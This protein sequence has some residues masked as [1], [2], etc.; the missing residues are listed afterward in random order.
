VER[1]CHHAG[2][3]GQNVND[4]WAVTLIESKLNEG[5][6]VISYWY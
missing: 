6:S 5:L 2:E 3:Y 4:H 1:P